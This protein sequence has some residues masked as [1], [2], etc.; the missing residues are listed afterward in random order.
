MFR[1]EAT[2]S[3]RRLVAAAMLILLEA[4][5]GRPN[6]G[7]PAKAPSSAAEPTSVIVIGKDSAGAANAVRRV[8]G[9]VSQELGIIDAVSAELTPEQIRRLRETGDLVGIYG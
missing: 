2:S 8:G 7:R 1:R 6:S 3:G 4:A 5:V 9:S